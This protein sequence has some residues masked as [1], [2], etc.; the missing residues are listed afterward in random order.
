MYIYVETK[1][2]FWDMEK[3]KATNFHYNHLD[4]ILRLKNVLEE[5]TLMELHFNSLHGKG[6]HSTDKKKCAIG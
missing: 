5:I 4:D 6:I 2:N 1:Q 3:I